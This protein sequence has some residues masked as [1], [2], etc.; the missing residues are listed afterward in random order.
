MSREAKEPS[1]EG[2]AGS[3]KKLTPVFLVLHLQIQPAQAEHLLRLLLIQCSRHTA[4]LSCWT[5]MDSQV[6]LLPKQYSRIAIYT[7]L[8]FNQ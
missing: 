2:F 8:S 5:Y 7:E 6:S 4:A 1:Y 3:R